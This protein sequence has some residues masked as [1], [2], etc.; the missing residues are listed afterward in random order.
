MDKLLYPPS[1]ITRRATR[2]RTIENTGHLTSPSEPIQSTPE[3]SNQ[4][5]IRCPLPP[6]GSASVVS[7][8]SLLSANA[9]PYYSS[10]SGERSSKRF[11]ATQGLYISGVVPATQLQPL[12]TSQSEVGGSASGEPDLGAPT[13]SRKARRAA[14]KQ[15]ASGGHTKGDKH[16][17]A[18]E[19]YAYKLQSRPNNLLLRA[20]RC[21]QQYIVD[22][23][24]KIE[25]TRL[26]FFRKNQDTIRADLYQ[27]ILDTVERGENSAANVGRRVVLPPT[28]IGGPRDLKKR[29]LNAMSLVHRYGKPDLFVTM[30]YNPA[31]PEIKQ[32]LGVGE[33]AQNRPDLVSRIFRAKLLALK[34]QIMQKHVFGEDAALIY[35]VEFQKRGLPHAHFLIILK[36]DFK[37]KTPADYDTSTKKLL[38]GLILRAFVRAFTCASLAMPALDISQV[39][40]IFEPAQNYLCAANLENVPALDNFVLPIFEY[41]PAQNKLCA[42]NF[43]IRAR[44]KQTFCCQFF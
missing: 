35:V 3:S 44:T 21:F 43:R 16:I 17:S 33:D 4:S 2:Q 40:P 34:K 12:S 8:A 9:F 28:F 11:R 13:V 5:K 31:W 36:P 23:Y 22:M 27:G 1:P 29:Y 15:S 25:N 38:C 7:Q 18:R 30:T 41:V 32:E 14:R 24:V 42:A 6:L 39:L 20:G 37:I 26:D 10:T 19:Y